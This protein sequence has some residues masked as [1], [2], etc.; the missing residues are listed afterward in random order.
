MESLKIEGVEYNLIQGTSVCT[1][2]AFSDYPGPCPEGSHPCVEHEKVLI[3]VRKQD[4]QKT[5]EMNRFFGK[6]MTEQIEMFPETLAV[7]QEEDEAWQAQ[8]KS[9]ATGVTDGSKNHDDRLDAATYIKAIGTD[10]RN[11]PLSVQVGGG[12]YK[13]MAIQPVEYITKNNLPYCEANVIKYISRW[14]EKGG[15][16]DLEKAKHYIDML[17]QLENL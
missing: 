4:I 15:K 8:Q 1:G 3:W 16:K 12:H 9:V 11:D 10:P 6:S 7:T 5:V 14:R 2:C 17:I 13:S